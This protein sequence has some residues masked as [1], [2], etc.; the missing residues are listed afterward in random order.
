MEKN[1]V[2]VR[3][4]I[5]SIKSKNH[6]LTG[7]ENED[8]VIREKNN[9]TIIYGIADG[10][11]G[12]KYC[13]T[14]A[15]RV[16][17]AVVEYINEN[18][19]SALEKREFPDE[20]SFEVMKVIRTE[21]NK[22]AEEYEEDKKEFS[23]TLLVVVINLTDGKYALIHL[24]DGC[25]VGKTKDNEIKMISA[26][27][28]GITRRYTWLTTSENALMHLK[29]KFGNITNYRRVLIMSDGMECICHGKNI[30]QQGKKLI[31]IGSIME[32]RNSMDLENLQDDATCI[33]V[34]IK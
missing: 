21:L 4:S 17:K 32:I 8:V 25:V 19:L 12:K 31:Q 20:I 18:Q 33:I 22:M 26:P 30:T 2:N 1:I 23:S 13:V 10:Q 9:N 16:L 34:E 24:G 15:Q 5:L 27:D 11:S 29:I 14:G 28:N 6:I 3:D 7:N